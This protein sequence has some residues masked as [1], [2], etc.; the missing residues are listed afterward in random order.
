MRKWRLDQ[1]QLFVLGEEPVGL[2][3]LQFRPAGLGA[4]VV[5][6]VPES[7]LWPWVLPAPPPPLPSLSRAGL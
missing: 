7:R 5:A 2:L 6:A 3:P 1:R 4:L